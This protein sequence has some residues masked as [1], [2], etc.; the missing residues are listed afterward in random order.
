M[1]HGIGKNPGWNRRS[2]IISRSYPL[3]L[4]WSIHSCLK[5]FLAMKLTGE[6]INLQIFEPLRRNTYQRRSLEHSFVASLLVKELNVFVLSWGILTICE[7]NMWTPSHKMGI[8]TWTNVETSME[9]IS[10]IEIGIPRLFLM[11]AK[12]LVGL[13]M[14]YLCFVGAEGM[15]HKK[16]SIIIPFPIP[17]PY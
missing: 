5:F 3:V 17:I 12:W 2:P 11:L 13:G 10:I 1:G 14:N 16:L 15:I 6:P 8:V 7:G 9:G 4:V